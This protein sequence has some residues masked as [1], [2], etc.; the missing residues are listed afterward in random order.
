MTGAMVRVSV[1][2]IVAPAKTSEVSRRF[3]EFFYPAISRQAGFLECVLLRETD[4][5]DTSG[6][7]HLRMDISFSSERE[8]LDWVET[9]LHDEVFGL[10]VQEAS[11]YEALHLSAVSAPGRT[12]H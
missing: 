8:R 3:D 12:G 10:L 2:I 9:D 5:N 7:Q 6:D 1:A 4:R 11:K